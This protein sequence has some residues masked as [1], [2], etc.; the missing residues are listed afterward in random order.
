MGIEAEASSQ[1]T[2]GGSRRT[3][4]LWHRKARDVGRVVGLHEGERAPVKL[5]RSRRVAAQAWCE[6]A[7]VLASSDDME[8]RKLGQSIVN[9][10][11]WLP[12]VRYKPLEQQMQREL[13]GVERHRGIPH[14]PT[15]ID[16]ASAQPQ[17]VTPE[18][19][20]GR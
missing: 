2:R 6:I 12:G 9:Y 8:D 19:D 11:R 13:R 14:G 16:P 7:K 3:E 4:R 20:R 5:T 1:I 17:R 18:P 15:R 10:A